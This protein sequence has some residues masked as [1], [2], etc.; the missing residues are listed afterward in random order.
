MD[1]RSRSSAGS[2]HI[3]SDWNIGTQV[4][5]GLKISIFK[6]WFFLPELRYATISNGYDDN[7][8]PRNLAFGNISI[9][10]GVMYTF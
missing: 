3:N 4:G 8:T 7:G 6:N 9:T 1:V 5:I 2:F 10:G